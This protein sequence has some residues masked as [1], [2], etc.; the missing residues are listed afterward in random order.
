MPGRIRYLDSMRAVAIL[1]V[2]AIH[3]KG[4]VTLPDPALRQWI[5]FI[6]YPVAVP[7]FFLVDGFLLA[8]KY[9]TPGT[10]DYNRF[11]GR[12]FARLV[13]PWLAFTIFYTL[14][15]WGFEMASLL[16]EQQV[17]GADLSRILLASYGSVY[18]PQLYFL[19]SL[20]FI[21]LTAPAWLV[22]FRWEKY[23]L[24]A[25]FLVYLLIYKAGIDHLVPYLEIRGG[26]EPILHALWGLQFYFLGGVLQAWGVE[27]RKLL[28]PVL[29]AAFVG[30]TAWASRFD[31]SPL[32][33]V[34]Q[35]LYLTTFFSL[36]A[37]FSIH[38]PLLDRLGTNTMGIYLLH[39]PILIKCFSLVLARL[40]AG[41][42]PS[43][44]ILVAATTISAYVLST[45]LRR[46][47]LSS[48]LLGE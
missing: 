2:V 4:G 44:L 9:P 13:V 22:V 32:H 16:D 11:I 5:D 14:A 15:R 34:V 31:T 43:Y 7:V 6:I 30:C 19:L 39:A 47:P 10:F 12:S 33:L 23:L 20:F 17:L 46:Y 29:L 41:P 28:F 37:A 21:R 18:A 26:Q 24:T 42:L 3:A 27:K 45:Y 1:M 8:K 36:F 35:Y 25:V 40:P 38:A 48:W